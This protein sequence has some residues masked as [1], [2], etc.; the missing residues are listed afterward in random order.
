LLLGRRDLALPT[1]LFFIFVENAIMSTNERATD[2]AIPGNVRKICECCAPK[3]NPKWTHKP[4]EWFIGKVVKMK[5]QSADSP[6]ELMWVLVKYVEDHNL[7]GTL[8]NDPVCVY[9]VLHGDRVVLNRTQI[10]DCACLD[11]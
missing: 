10:I 3:P 8:D 5:F 9:H 1:T 2:H 11:K 7:V 4:L 6:V